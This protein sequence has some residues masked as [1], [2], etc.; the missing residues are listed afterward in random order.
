M[1]MVEAR[2]AVDEA[3]K[4]QLD[5]LEYTF[6]IDDETIVIKQSNSF[7]VNYDLTRVLNEA[8]NCIDYT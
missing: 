7:I 5:K 3:H 2:A 4:E 1:T 8:F 6:N